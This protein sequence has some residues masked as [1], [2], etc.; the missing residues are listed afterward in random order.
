MAYLSASGNTKIIDLILR[1][2]LDLDGEVNFFVDLIDGRIILYYG[3]VVYLNR[4]AR[5]IRY[6]E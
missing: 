6:I 5:Y 3:T 1:S 4:G 2:C